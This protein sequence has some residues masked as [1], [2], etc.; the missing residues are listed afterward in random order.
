M[1]MSWKKMGAHG[2]IGMTREDAYRE[3]LLLFQGG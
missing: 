3:P 1:K 2:R